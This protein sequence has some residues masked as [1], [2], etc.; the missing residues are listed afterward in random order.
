MDI[1]DFTNSLHVGKIP[2]RKANP[3]DALLLIAD[4]IAELACAVDRLG[5]ADASTPMGGLEAL[6]KVFQERL[7]DI[8]DAIR[9]AGSAN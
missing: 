4:S 7:S 2:P 3:I 1:D 5:N 8:S 9:E 6:G